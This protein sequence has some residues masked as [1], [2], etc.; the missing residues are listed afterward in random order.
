M[1][2]VEQIYAENLKLQEKVLKLERQVEWL[3]GKLFG[4]GQGETMDRAQMLLQLEILERTQRET[5]KVKIEYE[6]A[7]KRSEKSDTDAD[8]YAKLPVAETIVIEPEEVKL[9]PHLYERIG[10][11]RTFELDV[12]DPKIVKREIVRPKYRHVVERSLPPV[13]APAPARAVPGGHVSSGLISWI[14]I[15]KYVDHL[16]LF[17]L[18]KQTQRMGCRI[19]RQTMSDAVERGAELLG[20]IHG[21]MRVELM[22]EGYVQ[23]DETPVRCQD[24]DVPGRTAEGWLWGMSHPKGDVV[25]QWRMSRRHAEALSLL[26]GY[27]GLMQSDGYAAYAEV[28]EQNPGITRVGCWAHARR[29]FTDVLKYAPLHA[30]FVLRLIGHLYAM[31][32]SWDEEEW[33]PVQRA[34]LRRRDMAMTLSL[35]NRVAKRMLE[36]HTP[37]SPMGEAAGYLLRQWDVL[38]A[39][40][41][42][43]ETRLDNNL[44]E[45]AI[46]PTAIGKK[47]WLFIGHPDAGQRSAVIYSIVVSCQRRGIDPLVYL[48]DV[49]GRLPGMTTKDDIAALTPRN[50]A[51]A[52]ASAT[53]AA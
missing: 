1:P 11:E 35:L 18:E 53:T 8:R 21:H 32:R 3:K 36:R 9:Q 16:P 25:F 45:N 51:L 7:A 12:Q 30:G 52:H 44:M 33:S 50:W 49:L 38:V 27:K 31:E 40:L 15:G 10:E 28:G 5:E 23:V 34:H 42:H 6:R 37:K 17:R 14:L 29:K 4:A 22:G 2:P 26:R 24:P 13:V 46:R 43:G 47:N 48:R 19:S 41:E 39:H 20:L